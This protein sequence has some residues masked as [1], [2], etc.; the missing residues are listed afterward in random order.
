MSCAKL[1]R[2]GLQNGK[3]SERNERCARLCRTN[4]RVRA[5]EH[6]EHISGH[7]RGQRERQRVGA[8]R[9]GGRVPLQAPVGLG[10]ADRGA[11][12]GNAVLTRPARFADKLS[13]SVPFDACGSGLLDAGEVHPENRRNVTAVVHEVRRLQRDGRLAD[14]SRS[15]DTHATAQM[16]CHSQLP[17]LQ[18]AHGAAGVP[19][20]REQGYCAL[21]LHAAADEV[22]AQ[23][24]QALSRQ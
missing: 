17:A 8:Q 4:V 20:P 1:C 13:A 22:L 16:K 21:N 19:V 12:N 15:M 6:E 11:Q 14:T 5:V 23:R 7:Q 10:E 3:V 9:C 24:R 2:N 18:S